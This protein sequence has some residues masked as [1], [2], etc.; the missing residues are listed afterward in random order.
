MNNGIKYLVGNN[1]ET[2]E[3]NCISVNRNGSVGYSFYHKYPA[4]Y[5]NDCRKLR[6]KK[7][8]NEYVSLFM[9]NQIMQQKDKYNY[10]IKMGTSRLKKQ[11]IML[12]V[13]ECGE[14]D[15]I[16]MEKY[17]KLLVMKKCQ[18]YLDYINS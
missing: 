10:S 15:Y 16:F 4:L 17:G 5:S 18:Q 13:S 2:L 6:L 7:C 1:N 14:P 9:T 8:N 12:P 11:M 3:S